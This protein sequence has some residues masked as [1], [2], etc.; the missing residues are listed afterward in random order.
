MTVNKTDFFNNL[1]SHISEPIYLTDK[2]SEIN[3]EINSNNWILSAPMDIISQTTTTDFLE[4]IQKVKDN[5]KNQLDKSTLD[6]DLIFYMWY[7]EMAGQLRFNFINSNHSKLP[8][9]CKLTHLD[10]P[11]EIVDKYLKSHYNDG[12]PMNEL[13]T[14]ETQEQIEEAER[15]KKELRDNFVLIVY[16]EKIKKQK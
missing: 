5:Y 12:I 1:L 2:T 4:F 8:F 16:Q 6:I 10:R 15:H 3:A 9:G 14:N 11:E 13:E 7:D